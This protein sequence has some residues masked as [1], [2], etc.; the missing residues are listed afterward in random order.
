MTGDI[1][2]GASNQLEPF[3]WQTGGRAL[4]WMQADDA[5]T[6]TPPEQSPATT[7]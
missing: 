6:A 2:R 7:R 1:E 3:P 4:K 5:L